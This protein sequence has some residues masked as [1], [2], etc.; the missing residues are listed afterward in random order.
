MAILLSLLAALPVWVL[1]GCGDGQA[2]TRGASFDQERAW[3]HLEALVDLGP[4]PP[5]S[6]AIEQARVYLE[7]RLSECGLEPVR[8]SFTAETP[9]GPL[10]MVNV[11]A[12]LPAREDPAREESAGILV[13]CTHYDTK[14]FDDFVFVGANDGGSGTAVLLELARVLASDGPGPLTYRF[15]FLDGEE[16]TRKLWEGDVDHTYGSRHHVAQLVKSGTVR[17]VKACILLDLVGDADLRL[18]RETYSDPDLLEF[19][20]AAA[21]ANGMQV[22]V[23]GRREEI[24]DD[25]LEFMAAD[26][27]SVDLIDLDYGRFNAYWH[28]EQDTLDKCSAMS[29]GVVGRIVLLGLPAVERRYAR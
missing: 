9:R 5:G 11:Y 27:P 7:A 20:F 13:L 23:D 8:E 16:A 19:F 1:A 3:K 10:E 15:L 4:R 26:I 22:H 14:I 25:H 17:R 6:P 29:L 24:R 21:R 18:H 2:A 12:D 28:S